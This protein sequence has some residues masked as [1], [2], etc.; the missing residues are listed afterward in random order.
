M[1]NGWT[2]RVSARRPVS[3]LGTLALGLW[4]AAGC[5][6][7]TLAGACD[8]EC[9]V[10]SGACTSQ[11]TLATGSSCDVGDALPGR[12]LSNCCGRLVSLADVVCRSRATVVELGAG[13]CAEC[14]KMA[15]DFNRWHSEHADLGLVQVLRDTEQAGEP[16]TR[17]F[18]SCW[19]AE[20]GTRFTLLIDPSDQL[21]TACASGGL[22]T[23]LV[24][25][26]DG[27]I[28]AKITG[29]APSEIEAAFSELLDSTR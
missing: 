17:E 27:R 26:S 12:V 20:L 29:E 25:S 9:P 10:V 1:S 15:P 11:P 23:T 21:T 24:V 18:C 22:P 6:D 3:A 13:W 2:G 7:P 28:T 8:Y 5:A 14:R 19:G 16:A 4:L